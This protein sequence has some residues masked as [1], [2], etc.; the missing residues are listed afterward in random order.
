MQIGTR[1]TRV[2]VRLDN[3]T[4]VDSEP[5]RL[6]RPPVL[7]CRFPTLQAPPN[8]ATLLIPQSLASATGQ[9]VTLWASGA[10][11]VELRR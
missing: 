3:G 7:E 4:T 9:A 10:P 11:R 8:R 6:L 5:C 1:G 2:A